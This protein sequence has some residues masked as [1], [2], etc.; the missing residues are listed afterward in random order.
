MQVLTAIVTSESQRAPVDQFVRRS[1]H[2][3]EHE[4]IM[5]SLTKYE[6]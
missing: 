1:S 3:D 5:C 6:I 2:I 4:G